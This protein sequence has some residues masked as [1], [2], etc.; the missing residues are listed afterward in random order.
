MTIVT[1]CVEEAG[2]AGRASRIAAAVVA[3]DARVPNGYIRT[4]RTHHAA[5]RAET[6]LPVDTG[7]PPLDDAHDVAAATDR[8]QEVAGSSPASSTFPC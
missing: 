1:A 3:A 5:V 2:S 8:T 7:I 6:E 4:R